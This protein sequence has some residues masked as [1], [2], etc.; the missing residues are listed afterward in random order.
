MCSS[1]DVTVLE[2]LPDELLV[3]ILKF[4]HSIERL[5]SF[6][7]LNSRFDQ[8]LREVGVG[9]EDDLATKEVIDK[10]GERIIFIRCYK[11][12]EILDLN[13]FRSIR[14]LTLFDGILSQVHSINSH[15]MLYISH[16]SLKT[17]S[18]SNMN[19][20][21]TN[22]LRE[23][24][25]GK[26]PWLTS[27]HLSNAMFDFNDE[28]FNNFTPCFRIRSATIGLC[29]VSFFEILLTYLPSLIFLKIHIGEWYL[30]HANDNAKVLPDEWSHAALSILTLEIDYPF[31]E[32]DL[33]WLEGRLP[34]LIFLEVNDRYDRNHLL[35]HWYIEYITDDHEMNE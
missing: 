21:H 29:H 28:L 22:I 1:H 13:Q 30:V 8:C 14:S 2:S 18:I 16:I 25:H 7:N 26:F 24:L 27:I 11:R 20:A 15:S 33:E 32:H 35:H 10:F 34:A 12:N 6:N 9:I 19:E 4:I 3:I 17:T 23:I 5:R 31:D